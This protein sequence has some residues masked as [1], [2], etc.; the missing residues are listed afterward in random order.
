MFLPFGWGAA[1]IDLEADGDQDVGFVGGIIE[2]SFNAGSPGAALENLGCS[3]RFIRSD[4]LPF[5]N[6]NNLL[7][8]GLSTGDLN[9]DGF[10]DLVVVAGECGMCDRLLRMRRYIVQEFAPY[11]G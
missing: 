9:N 11:H 1:A 10:V 8:S 7:T 2:Y 4:A 5:R 6:Y 3:G